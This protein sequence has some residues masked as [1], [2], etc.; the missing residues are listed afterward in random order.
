MFIRAS[1]KV[2]L[3]KPDLYLSIVVRISRFRFSPTYYDLGFVLSNS[4]V[5]F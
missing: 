5:I 3:Y 4:L 2:R 1:E